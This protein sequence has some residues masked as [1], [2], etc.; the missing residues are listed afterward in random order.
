MS[1]PTTVAPAA[2]AVIEA[3][4]PS[5]AVD[6]RNG[7]TSIVGN[8]IE[9]KKRVF[10]AVSSAVKLGENLNT[11]LAVVDILVQPVS[12]ENEDTGVVE[13]YHRITLLTKDGKAYVAGSKG[14]YNSVQNILDIFRAPSTWTEPLEVVAVE[15]KAPRGKYFALEL[16]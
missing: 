12:G 16:V 13:E 10:K 15:R 1:N 14:L 3:A 5:G 8:D 4:G 2:L 11:T 7:Y 9:T 6:I